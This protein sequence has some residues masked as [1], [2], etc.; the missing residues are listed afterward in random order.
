[1]STI[2]IYNQEGKKVSERTVAAGIFDVKPNPAVIQQVVVA[3]RANARQ[4]VAST[5][6]RSEVRG[7]GKKPWKQKG[8]GRARHGSIRSPL[9]RGGGSTF[10]PT[11]DRNFKLKINK[12]VRRKALLMV[13]SDKVAHDGLTVVDSLDFPTIKTKNFVAVLTA[14]GLRSKRAKVSKGEVKKETKEKVVVKKT[15]Q[16][17]ILIVLA[18]KDEKAVK[19]GRNIPGVSLITI[20]TLNVLDVI[21]HKRVLM[22]AGCIDALETLYAKV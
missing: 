8:T 10:G 16:P 14:L 5:K 11:T 6:D 12:K 1:M 21:K 22:A 19:S 2:T 18:A 9:W 3:M 7:G 13:L 17:S 4:V 20:K 15:K